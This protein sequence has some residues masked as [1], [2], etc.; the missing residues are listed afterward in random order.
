MGM[1]HRQVACG[2]NTGKPA[3]QSCE[4]DCW[5]RLLNSIDADWLGKV[6]CLESGEGHLSMLSCCSMIA[7]D[8]M[9]G[10]IGDVLL[11]RAHAGDLCES[12]HEPPI[13]LDTAH[14]I[15]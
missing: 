1:I 8:S 3:G 10:S 5:G 7:R 14:F 4:T 9:E 15:P 13:S 6:Y 2:E 12:F 11:L